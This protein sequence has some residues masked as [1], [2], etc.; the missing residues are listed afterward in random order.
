MLLLSSCPGEINHFDSV[1]FVDS[2][3]VDVYSSSP[4]AF[5][6]LELP[7]AIFDFGYVFFGSFLLGSAIGCINALITKFT[8]ICEFPLL[9][10]ALFILLSYISFLSAE[11]MGLTGI[12]AVLFCGICQAH[13][14]YN[15]LSNEAKVRTKQ[16]FETISFLSESFIFLYI[17]VN[18][19]TA[20]SDWSFVFL[21]SSLVILRSRYS[22]VD[23]Y[24]LQIAITAG[25]ALFVYPL[26]NLLNLKRR[27]HIPKN[28]QHMLVF[29]GLRGA[30]PFAIAS[31]NTATSH[32]Q[33]MQSTTS[34]IVLITVCII[35]LEHSTSV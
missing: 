19:A 13:Y 30:V 12:V 33:I 29:A 14:T 15:N 24:L 21:F 28:H 34:M 17:G 1:D 26:C 31:R 7:H 5:T 27:P 32:R 22:Y 16:F 2:S 8:L 9:E 6:L 10:S 11:V 4:N 20:R 23:R 35:S 3:I 18:L 25:R